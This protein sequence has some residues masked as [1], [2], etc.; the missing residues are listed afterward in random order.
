MV[1]Y[2]GAELLQPHGFVGAQREHTLG[3]MVES[4]VDFVQRPIAC[5][6]RS[7]NSG[8]NS[9]SEGEVSRIVSIYYAE[10][11]VVRAV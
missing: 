9:N 2:P 4:T 7:C 1:S 10:Y 6:D 8:S 11:T 5:T 3:R